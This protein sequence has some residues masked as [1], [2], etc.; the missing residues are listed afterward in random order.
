MNVGVSAFRL[1]STISKL[2]T[3]LTINVKAIWEPSMSSRG[4]DVDIV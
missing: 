3:C 2:V 4:Y 1:L